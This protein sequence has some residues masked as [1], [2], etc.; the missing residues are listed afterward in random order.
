MQQSHRNLTQQKLEYLAFFECKYIFMIIFQNEAMLLLALLCLTVTSL[1]FIF[2]KVS[3]LPDSDSNRTSTVDGLRGILALSV[4]AHHFYITYIWKTAG[5]WEKPESIVIDNFGAVA[6]SLFFLITGYLFISKIRKDK[7]SWKQLYISRIKRIVPLYLFVFLFILAIT[8]LNVQITASNFTEF[9]KWVSDWIFFKGGSFQNF[10]SGR[11][12]AG[13]HWTLIYEWKFYFA[14]PLIFAIW[15]QKIPKWLSSIL[16]IAFIIYVFK[17]KSH[18]VYAL[19][20]LSI[21]AVLYKDRFKQ[22]M[23]TKPAI[24]H[25]VVCT[26]SIIALF[27]TEAYSWPQMLSLAVIFSFIVC[28]YSFGVLNHKG[29]KVL[30]EISYSIY[31]VHGLVLYILFTVINIVDLKT[32]SLEKYYLFFFPAALLVS[33]VSLFTYKFIEFPFLRKPLKSSGRGRLDQPNKKT[34]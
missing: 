11:V 26:L 33:I 22:F 21:P 34:A 32:I 28:G 3:I 5:D 12:I 7:V 15:Q 27:L 6:V 8:L 24:T 18:H 2:T 19:F 31:L 9:L 25:I 10:E 30:G 29:L 14:L 23:Q 20:F 13:V 4:M 1:A 16:F 17:H